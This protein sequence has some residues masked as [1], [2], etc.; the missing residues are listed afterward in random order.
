MSSRTTLFAKK[1]DLKRLAD[2]TARAIQETQSRSYSVA[3]CFD[4][5]LTVLDRR[6]RRG[7]PSIAAEVKALL[8]QLPKGP[9][10]AEEPTKEEQKDANPPSN[11][12]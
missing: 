4:A 12:G 2:N 6:R 9:K 10:L 8:E 5:L 7:T 11:E 1:E 3:I